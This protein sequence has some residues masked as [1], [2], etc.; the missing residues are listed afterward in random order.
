MDFRVVLTRL[1]AAFEAQHI[2]YA[3]IGGL[4][5]GVWG[6]HR[7]TADIDFLIEQE[8]LAEVHDLLTWLGYQRH[9]YSVN[10][11]QYVSDLRLWGQIDILHALRP[12]SRRMLAQ[13]IA[14]EL[15]QGTMMVRVARVEDLIGLKVQAIVNDPERQALDLADIAALLRIHG[16]N[17]DWH[18]IK[19]Y[20]ALFQQTALFQRLRE[21]YGPLP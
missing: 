2:R 11:S 9:Y 5:L 14:A 18:L 16:P 3:L 17:L 19:E 4:A 8:D 21:Q 12:A 20:C 10:V 7:A 15:F 6:V 1:I 13:A